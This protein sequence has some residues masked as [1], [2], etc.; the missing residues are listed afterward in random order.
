MK[1]RFLAIL[2]CAAM[3]LSL[4]ACGDSNNNNTE[5]TQDVI[6]QPSITELASYD[7][8]SEVLTG[9]YEITD[10][11]IDAYFSTMLYNAGVGVM[12][13]TDRDTVQEGDIVK[14]DYTGYLDG[15]AFS[16][17]AATDQW[18]D[19]SNNCGFDITSGSASTGYIDGFSD[20]IL[21]AKIGEKKSSEVTFP[22]T[23]GNTDLAGKVT[24]FEFTVHEI[25]VEITPD[26]ITDAFVAENLNKLY[27]VS[28]VEEFMQLVKEELAYY[29]TIDYVITNS[30]F[31]IPESYLNAR[32]ESLEVY[33]TETYCMG[34]T[35]EDYLAYYAGVTIDAARAQWIEMLKS[36]IKEEL[37]FAAIVENAGLEVDEEEFNESVETIL[38]LELEQ[39]PDAES[40][41]KDNGVGDAA[42]GEAYMK[43]KMAVREYL[44]E[45]YNALNAE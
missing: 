21:G 40:I 12:K 9:D 36:K 27:E 10:E 45:R 41:Y 18:I 5:G 32:L 35:L 4:C 11:Y 25:Y 20:G 42:A 19:V 29:F 44:I 38:A 8:L 33:F 24:T 37:V 26:N 17:G 23:Y 6:G 2:L 31:D 39:Y 1:M 28:T 16:G 13:V 15:E 14:V 7:D 43:N 3:A 22:E 30:T 34:M